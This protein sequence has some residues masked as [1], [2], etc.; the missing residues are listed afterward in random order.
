MTYPSMLAKI[1]GTSLLHK[2]RE[3][4]EMN[5]SKLFACFMANSVICIQGDLSLI[6][7]D[8]LNL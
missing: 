4:Q 6:Q 7:I 1:R 5:I 3:E 2:R 8:K